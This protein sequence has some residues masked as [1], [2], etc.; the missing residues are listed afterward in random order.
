MPHSAPPAPPSGGRPAPPAAPGST[1]TLPPAPDRGIVR[2][3]HASTVAPIS[4]VL[5]SLLSLTPSYIEELKGLAPKKRRAKLPYVVVIAVLLVIGVL[6]AG[7]STREFAISKGREIAAW[8]RG[9]PASAP[10]PAVTA[11]E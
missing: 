8:W 1:P 11:P 9:A 3:G 6:A 5:T 4:E 2:R 10:A 7:A